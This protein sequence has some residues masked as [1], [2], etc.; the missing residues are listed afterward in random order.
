MATNSVFKFQRGH[1]TNT[2]SPNHPMAEVECIGSWWT[3]YP[4]RM[5]WSI[6]TPLAQTCLFIGPDGIEK[7]FWQGHGCSYWPPRIP[8]AELGW[9]DPWRI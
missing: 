6:A 2:R 3:L 5:D 1:K 9:I 7:W 4:L 8:T